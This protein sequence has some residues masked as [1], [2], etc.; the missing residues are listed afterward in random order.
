[1]LSTEL[2]LTIAASPSLALSDLTRLNRLNKQF[3]H[4]T[5]PLLYSH[6]TLNI[7][8]PIY[9]ATLSCLNGLITTPSRWAPINSL[10]LY[11]PQDSS[12]WPLAGEHPIGIALLDQ[13]LAAAIKTMVRLRQFCWE[14]PG[15]LSGEETIG[16][17]WG[18]RE[19]LC[20]FN[21]GSLRRNEESAFFFFR[22]LWPPPAR[23][24]EEGGCGLVF[25]FCPHGLD[26][27]AP[28][29]QYRL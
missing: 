20:G 15:R 21:V 10:T 17:L 18:R 19:R 11:A 2:L 9:P 24:G 8:N 26:T 25:S 22:I 6:L 1:M 16:A 13:K 3:H 23:N 28:T 29:P 14:I 12:S 7:L 5:S 27:S 4:R